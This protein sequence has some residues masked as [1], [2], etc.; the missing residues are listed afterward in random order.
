MS[1]QKCPICQ[2][3]GLVNEP[4]SQE[5]C[6]VCHGAK[7]ID[8]QTGQ[9]PSLEKVDFDVDKLLKTGF[10]GSVIPGQKQ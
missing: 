10:D 9:P 7:I 1:Y 2:G 8:E 3:S 5:S 6:S 4:Y